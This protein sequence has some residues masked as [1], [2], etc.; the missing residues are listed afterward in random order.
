MSSSLLLHYPH[1]NLNFCP[2]FYQKR[3]PKKSNLTFNALEAFI[4]AIFMFELARVY[5]PPEMDSALSNY[6]SFLSYVVRHFLMGMCGR[7]LNRS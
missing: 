2:F 1:Y 7:H 3:I 4:C 6:M 5:I